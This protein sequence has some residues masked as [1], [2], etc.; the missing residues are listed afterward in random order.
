MVDDQFNTMIM[1]IS[2]NTFV[3]IHKELTEH[4]HTDKCRLLCSPVIMMEDNIR[5]HIGA[6]LLCPFQF[7]LCNIFDQFMH[8]F[9]FFVKIHHSIL[10][11]TEIM[12]HL[13][14]SRCDQCGNH[15]FIPINSGN[16]LLACFPVFCCVIDIRC[17]Y[18]FFPFCDIRAYQMFG[19]MKWKRSW[20][21][22][23]PGIIISPATFYCWCTR[24]FRHHRILLLIGSI[25]NKG[26][27]LILFYKT[28]RIS[29]TDYF[30]HILSFC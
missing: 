8:G 9:R 27:S 2:V 23:R 25:Q 26:Q 3:R 15:C 19:I 13:K 29:S 14:N 20:R 7:P 24:S 1:V 22:C 5:F 12:A 30:H 28:I 21:S 16:G 10:N 4:I 18:I 11:F 17:F 6:D